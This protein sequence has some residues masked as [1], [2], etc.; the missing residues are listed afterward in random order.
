MKR[1]QSLALVSTMVLAFACS[2]DD[3][4]ITPDVTDIIV[5]SFEPIDIHGDCISD[6]AMSNDTDSTDVIDVG[7]S[8]TADSSDTFVGDEGADV[9]AEDVFETD[10][11]ST[12]TIDDYVKPTA[13]PRELAIE[14]T[15]ESAGD[16][17]TNEEISD[18]TDRVIGFYKSFDYFSWVLR[19]TCG[20]DVSTELPDY[21]LWWHDADMVKTDDGITF[22]HCQHGG[23]HNVMISTSKLL[24][25]AAAYYRATDDQAAGKVCEQLCKGI[26]ATMK[27]MVFDENDEVDWLM[28]R[29]IYAFAQEYEIEPNKRTFVDYSDCYN[30]YVAWNTNRFNYPDNPTWGDIWVTNERS[31]DDVCHLFR[32]ASF[33]PI[34]VEDANDD[35]VADACRETWE[36]LEKFSRDIVDSGYFI[37]SKDKN[38]EIYIPTGQDK[39]LASF[40]D[41]MGFDPRNECPA[42]MSSV[43]MGYGEA[44]ETVNECDGGYPTSF[45][46][47][48]AIT[49]FFNYD[50]FR[51]FHMASVGLALLK[52][53]LPAARQMLQ[54]LANRSTDMMHPS[55]DEPGV[56]DS[57][58]DE[59]NA[60]VLLQSASVGLPLTDEEALLIQTM[61]GNSIVNYSTFPNWD[62]WD[63]SV[64]NG[65]Y[66]PMGGM[67]PIHCDDCIH[68]E[69]MFFLFEYCMS[70]Y[71][72][73]TGVSPVDCNRLVDAMRG[74]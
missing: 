4:D 65:T 28:A 52:W 18:F 27:G 54:G 50:I 2:S 1:F 57:R 17:L 51:N 20:V 26:T 48:S 33:L 68:I 41:Y 22:K 25:E 60:L 5:D 61:Y 24:S 66:I 16:A 74:N 15:R 23:D 11:T 53:E 46:E 69:D 39:D 37:R 70:P 40:V 55:P 29:N 63:E 36:Y 49:H 34:L 19:T 21:R 14:F 47:I 31:K 67:R 45:D 32:A 7:D 64:A 10:S 59:E 71:R 12:D 73:P 6:T 8:F 56:S 38:G 30:E 13:I 62:L 3:S 58:W 42:R 43:L 35:Y 72:N 9:S 44:R